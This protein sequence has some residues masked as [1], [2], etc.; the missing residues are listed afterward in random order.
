[1]RRQRTPCT[2]LPSPQEDPSGPQGSLQERLRKE[3]MKCAGRCVIEEPQDV[4]SAE[5]ETN[6]EES[7][8]NI[9]EKETENA[10]TGL[11]NSKVNNP[12]T[13]RKKITRG[14]RLKF[15]LSLGAVKAIVPKDATP[16][17][18]V[19]KSKGGSFRIADGDVILN[20]GS[21]RLEGVGTLSG[22]ED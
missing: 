16:D 18:K 5:E 10:L 12:P 15:I 3:K 8:L 17:M 21:T 7:V 20:L 22:T 9:N 2:Q 19:D 14:H 6:A 4:S 1:M 13:W 11:Q